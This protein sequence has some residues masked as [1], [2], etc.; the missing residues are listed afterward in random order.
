MLTARLLAIDLKTLN[1]KI[2]TPHRSPSPRDLDLHV[3][4]HG[5]HPE[6]LLP[7][8]EKLPPL[9]PTV[10]IVEKFRLRKSRF[11]KL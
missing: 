7:H 10:A 1:K 6:E 9:K 2:R 3:R 4:P 11:P 5:S 8:Q